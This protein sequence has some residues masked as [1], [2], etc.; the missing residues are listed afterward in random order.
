MNVISPFF[1]RTNPTGGSGL[2]FVQVGVVICPPMTVPRCVLVR[3]GQTEWSKTGQHT[4]RTDLPLLPEGEKQAQSLAPVLAAYRFEAILTSPLIRA[5]DTCILAGAGEEAEVEPDLA[6]WHYGSYEGLT[7]DEIRKSRPGWNLFT[8]GAPGGE[9]ADQVGTRADRVIARIR[10]VDGDVVCFAHGH[11]L[12]VL[13]ARWIGLPAADAAHFLLGPASV[14]VLSWERESP[15]I[16][17]W[18]QC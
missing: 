3:H 1:A 18:N 8:D 7:T 12:R 13:A 10:H 4:G 16:A 5:R 15:V 9:V 6:E 17:S 2:A 14:S 11:V